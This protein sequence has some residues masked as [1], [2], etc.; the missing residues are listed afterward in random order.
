MRIGYIHI[1]RSLPTQSFRC[2]VLVS[3]S[4]FVKVLKELSSRKV[5]YVVIGDS[6]LHLATGDSFMGDD[7]DLFVFQPDLLAEEEFY[8]KLA[9]ELGW[10]VGQTWLGTPKLLAK[11][12]GE[13]VEVD[14][15]T[16]LFDFFISPEL[17]KTASRVRI[18]NFR[19][20]AL[21]PEAYLVLKAKF[22]DSA[23][24]KELKSFFGSRGFNKRK[25]EEYLKLMP[26]EDERVVRRKLRE[27]GFNV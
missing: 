3:R 23:R 18:N 17:L 10:G 8:H 12:E 19:V 5:K 21:E 14:L 2:G 15:Y 26:R 25:I 6:V 20:K 11:E 27:I 4:A 1:T 24:M 22:A 16:N 7:I 13:E 9:D